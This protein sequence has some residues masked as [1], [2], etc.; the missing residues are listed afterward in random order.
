M[1]TEVEYFVCGDKKVRIPKHATEQQ[2]N[3]SYKRLARMV[4]H[5]GQ[6]FPAEFARELRV[7]GMMRRNKGK[8]NKEKEAINIEVCAEALI[9]I[10]HGTILNL[11]RQY[12]SN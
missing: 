4:H 12:L 3:L 9:L 2:V 1:S 11:I 8:K 6:P 10:D 7:N 5:N